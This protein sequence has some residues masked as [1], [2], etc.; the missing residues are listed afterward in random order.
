MGVSRRDFLTWL[1]AGAATAAFPGCKSSFCCGPNA[2]VAV[3]LYS[4]NKYL[5]VNGF[6]KTIAD[7]AAI[8][9]DPEADLDNSP[10]SIFC[11]HGAGYVVKWDEVQQMMHLEAEL[12]EYKAP[13]APTAKGK[14]NYNGTK[15]EDD[16]LKAIFDVT[17]GTE[18]IKLVEE[19]EQECSGGEYDYFDASHLFD[20]L[21]ERLGSKN[22]FYDKENKFTNQI[23]QKERTDHQKHRK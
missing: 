23:N 2:R 3:Q 16:E 13:S 22:N 20:F 9:Y 11:S 18:R 4:I 14:V 17:G 8:G 12:E 10:D 21:Y 6:A 7:V 15:E 19:Y 5:G 1:G